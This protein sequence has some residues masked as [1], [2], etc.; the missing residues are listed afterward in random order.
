M[1]VLLNR[2]GGSDSL[3]NEKEN[4]MGRLEWLNHL[5][6]IF[7]LTAN[8]PLL[9]PSSISITTEAFLNTLIENFSNLPLKSYSDY[10]KCSSVKCI[11]FKDLFIMFENDFGRV[12]NWDHIMEKVMN[13]ELLDKKHRRGGNESPSSLDLNELVFISK[14]SSSSVDY[15]YENEHKSQKLGDL[16]IPNTLINLKSN[17]FITNSGQYTPPPKESQDFGTS[18]ASLRVPEFGDNLLSMVMKKTEIP[19]KKKPCSC[20]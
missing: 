7:N 9:S 14:L 13:F 15:D 4:V 20:L 1:D 12:L 5:S 19:T 18:K 8:I 10:T 6:L 2:V 17:S 11:S 16:R 3:K